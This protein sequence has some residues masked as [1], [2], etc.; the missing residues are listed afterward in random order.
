ME[1]DLVTTLQMYLS[2]ST[3]ALIIVITLLAVV[4]CYLFIYPV[5]RRLRMN[6]RRLPD[7]RYSLY[8]SWNWFDG[9]RTEKEYFDSVEALVKRIEK[10]ALSNFDKDLRQNIKV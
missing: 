6:V 9:S 4:C 8:Y 2:L 3:V 7:G 10:L 1:M 5:P